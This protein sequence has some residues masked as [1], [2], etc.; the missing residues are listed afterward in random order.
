[1]PRSSRGEEYPP[2]C[3]PAAFGS[4]DIAYGELSCDEKRG[5][6]KSIYAEIP[7]WTGSTVQV[8]FEIEDGKAR[9][10]AMQKDGSR[11]A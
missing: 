1:M 10:W 5:A 7:A 4:I 2:E 6:I 11:G 3:L 9:Y 8:E